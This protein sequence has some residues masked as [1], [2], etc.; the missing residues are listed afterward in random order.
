LLVEDE[1]MLSARQFDREEVDRK[2]QNEHQAAQLLGAD[3][4]EFL[5]IYLFFN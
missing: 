5:F 4:V 1:D 2:D 3:S